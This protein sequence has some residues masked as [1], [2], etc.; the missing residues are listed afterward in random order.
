MQASCSRTLYKDI[1]NNLF[2]GFS[3]TANIL[4][5]NFNGGRIAGLHS[6][7][8][9]MDTGK[10]LKLY[11][12]AR[13]NPI[14]ITCGESPK[15]S[16]TLHKNQN[17]KQITIEHMSSD[18]G[19]LTSLETLLSDRITTVVKTEKDRYW[20]GRREFMQVRA[21]IRKLNS[22]QDSVLP[23]STP[24]GTYHVTNRVIWII[25]G[26]LLLGALLWT[27]IYCSF[28]KAK[29]FWQRRQIQQQSSRPMM[30]RT[31]SRLSRVY[32]PGQRQ[33]AHL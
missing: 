30:M 1:S 9:G 21:D 31:Q 8:D 14:K 33:S 28:V 29:E 16:Y 25:I 10:T 4:E 5:A 26:I 23:V 15:R 7:E 13:K 3:S 24:L 12:M 20:N 32:S 6:K 19:D 2:V 27:V 18:V 11:S 22:T 17:K